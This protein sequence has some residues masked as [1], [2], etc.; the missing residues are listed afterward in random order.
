M[1]A[2]TPAASRRSGARGARGGANSGIEGGRARRGRRGS[3]PVASRA[4]AAAARRN[5][6]SVCPVVRGQVT[7]RATRRGAEGRDFDL[8]RS[9]GPSDISCDATRQRKGRDFDL[10]RFRGQVISRATGG[11]EARDFDLPR[12][13]GPSDISSLW[14]PHRP[15]EDGGLPTLPRCRCMRRTGPLTIADRASARGARPP[16]RRRARSVRRGRACTTIAS[17]TSRPT[18][19][20]RAGA[21]PVVPAHDRPVAV[22]LR[23]ERGGPAA[24]GLRGSGRWTAGQTAT[25]RAP[26]RSGRAPKGSAPRSARRP[27]RPSARAR[28]APP[29]RCRPARR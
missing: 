1:A 6:T 21:G 12:S 28:P 11:A 19:G 13:S 5:E 15:T 8:P 17:P 3:G 4:P 20:H 22:R 10:P 25:A 24:Q 2:R 18:S 9:S 16:T 29:P 7:S 27:S 14:G 23:L 26:T